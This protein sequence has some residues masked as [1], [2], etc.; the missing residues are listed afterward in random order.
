MGALWKWSMWL[1]INII[2]VTPI[3]SLS[4]LIMDTSCS[5]SSPEAREPWNPLVIVFVQEIH[6]LRADQTQVIG[7]HMLASRFL[8]NLRRE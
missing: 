4:L 7:V 1:V 6:Q 2:V 3:T 5:T 8:Y